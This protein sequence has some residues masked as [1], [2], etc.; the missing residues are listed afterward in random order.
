MQGEDD[1]ESRPGA[2]DSRAVWP[3]EHQL[4]GVEHFVDEV[5]E[6]LLCGICQNVMVKPHSC[7]QSGHTFCLW[8]ISRWLRSDATCPAC[9]EATQVSQL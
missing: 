2:G 1:G 7:C 4:M 6:E 9:R 5:E 8:C 3:D